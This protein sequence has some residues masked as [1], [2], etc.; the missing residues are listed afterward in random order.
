MEREVVMKVCLI[1]ADEIISALI[2]SKGNEIE[3]Y[4]RIEDP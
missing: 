1:T 4:P 2:V 3:E